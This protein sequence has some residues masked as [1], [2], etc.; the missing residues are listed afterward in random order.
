MGAILNNAMLLE[1]CSL[2]LD[3]V[4]FYPVPWT[5]LSV[6]IA[7]KVPTYS[8]F[9]KCNVQ[10]FHEWIFFL[11]WLLMS[12]QVN[13]C[14]FINMCVFPLVSQYIYFFT[15]WISFLFLLVEVS[16]CLNSGNCNSIVILMIFIWENL[17]LVCGN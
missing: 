16:K 1:F 15:S 11:P 17:V 4:L 2:F 10:A 7:I 6:I 14:A 13:M 5:W 12:V 9:S 3:N 8:I